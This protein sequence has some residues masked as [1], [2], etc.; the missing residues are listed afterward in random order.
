MSAYDYVIYENGVFRAP[1]DSL[2]RNKY[3]YARKDVNPILKDV[4]VE[5]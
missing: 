5:A 4:P 2:K 3:C 1:H